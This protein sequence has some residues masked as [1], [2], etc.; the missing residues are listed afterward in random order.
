MFSRR[1]W[2]LILVAGMALALSWRA[3]VVQSTAP[4]QS[5]PTRT[6]TPG[7]ATPQ[8]TATTGGGGSPPA[9]EEPADTPV[10]TEEP[11][12]TA[13]AT[14]APITGDETL[15]T[16]EACSDAPT[17]QALN[18]PINVRSGP[19]TA[20]ET[21][22]ELVYLEVRLITGRAEGAA[23]WQIQMPDGSL[24]WV[25]DELV[26]VSGYTG[27]VPRVEAPALADGS[28]PTPGPTWAPTP[29]PTCPSATPTATATATAT[30]TNTA[31]PTDTAT[32]TNTA[33]PAGA[34]VEEPEGSAAEAA[35]TEEGPPTPM[36]TVEPES[37]EAE[38]PA[39]AGATATL[40]PISDLEE[41]DAGNGNNIWLPVAGVL[42]IGAA[43]VLFIR[44]RQ[45][46]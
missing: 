38:P 44:G 24:A 30:P 33:T 41:G 16:A 25:L 45:A 15:P 3:E 36:P 14:S 17:I 40:S 10:P 46:T 12:G 35:A 21:I 18:S 43:I 11:G 22:G 19:G 2:W 1:S 29:N 20:Y 6:P 28:T 23:W 42:L 13:T 37:A 31:T 39:E 32:P 4:G 7:G 34:E 26:A 27:L 8:P 5:L 9:T